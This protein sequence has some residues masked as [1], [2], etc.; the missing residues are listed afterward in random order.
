VSTDPEDDGIVAASL[1]DVGRTRSENQDACGEF[2][3]TLGERLWIVADGMGGHR[4]GATA[5]R[6]CIEAMGQTFLEG[7][8]TPE[9]RLILGFERANE[10]VR[11]GAQQDP[12]LEGMGTTGVALL[13]D[14]ARRA[15]VAWVGDSR[16]YRLRQGRLEPL[17]RDHSVIGEWLRLGMITP[18]EAEVHPRRH[19]LL[20]ALGPAERAEVDLEPVEV[21]PGDRFLLCSDGLYGCVPDAEIGAVLG[22]EVP[23]VAAQK[24]VD[25]AN[26][27]GGGPDNITVQIVTIPDQGQTARVRIPPPERDPVAED[28][29][30]PRAPERRRH[31]IGLLAGGVASVA[32][33]LGAAAYYGIRIGG[34]GL[35]LASGPAPPPA[36][37][38][39]PGIDESEARAEERRW[40]AEQRR[41][42]A[43]TQRREA[44]ALRLR[45]AEQRE[46]TQSEIEARI[47]AQL[48]PEPPGPVAQTGPR[49]AA[50]VEAPP[51]SGG[52]PALVRERSA[53]ADA[54]EAAAPGPV[55]EGPS[56]EVAAA[57]AATGTPGSG[58]RAAG[59]RGTGFESKRPAA[60]LETALHGFLGS[61]AE[62]LNTG[63]Y[64]LYESLGFSAPRDQFE[65]EHAR[66]AGEPVSLELV[67]HRRWVG[68]FLS[69][70][71][72]RTSPG[73]QTSVEDVVLRETDAGLRFAGEDR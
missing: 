5:S 12:E 30:P 44:E 58:L 48:A 39:A 24:L 35:P 32:L 72:R 10:R 50:P 33:A 43:E 60:E 31:R 27:E 2:R 49:E 21:Q 22:F 15:W 20:R 37:D 17:S 6:L 9:E 64:A 29:G 70:R 55:A 57:E 8:G 62:A 23:E 52:S 40:I 18:E 65:R 61:W 13:I 42:A 54:P 59:S 19:E 16:A 46:A 25:K 4:G 1:S 47:G 53:T 28:P 36:A 7:E 45:R 14:A 51:P 11:A 56:P 68:R 69:V 63:N 41:R 38:E 26:R 34:G 66:R 71:F 67:S 3:G 73:G